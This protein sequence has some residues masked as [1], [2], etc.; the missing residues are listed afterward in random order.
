MDLLLNG[1]GNHTNDCHEGPTSHRTLQIIVLIRCGV[2]GVSFI[3]SVIA[4]LLT[5]IRQCSIATPSKYK[6]STLVIERLFIYLLIT[7]ILYSLACVF[8]F[9]VILDSSEPNALSCQINA[10][11]TVYLNWTFTLMSFCVALQLLIYSIS[12]G[13]IDKSKREKWLK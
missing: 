4:C 3:M 1:S 5:I 7:S 13:N 10:F 6:Q 8:Q 2:A 12:H 9:V 11:F